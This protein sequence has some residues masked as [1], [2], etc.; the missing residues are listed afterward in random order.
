ML[1]N[2]NDGIKHDVYG[3]K[4]RVH[5]LELQVKPDPYEVHAC[6]HVSWKPQS[7]QK[8]YREKQCTTI[9]I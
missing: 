1:K 5:R 8:V 7:D 9:F 2:K 6:E 3:Y 4:R